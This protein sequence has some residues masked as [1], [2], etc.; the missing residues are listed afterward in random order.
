M[1]NT[2][3]GKVTLTAYQLF[4]PS[5]EYQDK[6]INILGEK[7]Q[8]SSPFQLISQ[9]IKKK[10][11]LLNPGPQSCELSNLNC[12]FSPIEEFHFRAVLSLIVRQVPLRV[13]VGVISQFHVRDESGPLKAVPDLLL[14]Y[15]QIVGVFIEHLAELQ[16]DQSSVHVHEVRGSGQNYAVQNNRK[17]PAEEKKRE[18]KSLNF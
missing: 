1:Q 10:L 14:P 6:M 2:A 8:E 12:D 17:I 11:R 16:D 3:G 9:Q 13:R 15:L 7:T 5:A 18:K 4:S